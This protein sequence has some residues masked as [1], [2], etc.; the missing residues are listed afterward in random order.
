MITTN[1]TPDL[2]VEVYIDGVLVDYPG[3]WAD[4]ASAQLWAADIVAAVE[5]GQIIYP[6]QEVNP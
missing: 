3:P 6:Q 4:L 5:S 1:I 2:I